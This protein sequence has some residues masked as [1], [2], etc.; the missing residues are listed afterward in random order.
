M[1]S[2]EKSRAWIEVNRENLLYN[3][4]VAR[5]RL[6]VDTKIMAVV[7]AQAYGH[8]LVEVSK[9]FEEKGV[10]F[11]A[12]ACLS[13]AIM[14][15]EHGICGDIL[16]LGYTDI[17]CMDLVK[18]YDIIQ[19]GINCE[20]VREID[21]LGL[22]IRIHLKV[23]T[24]MH[25]IGE[26]IEHF[27]EIRS[28]FDLE[29][30]KLEGVFSHL[31]VSDM[32]Y[33]SYDEFTLGQIRRYDEMI[34]RLFES[35]YQFKTHIQSSSGMLNYETP[36]FHSYVRPGIMLYGV[37][38]TQKDLREEDIMLKPALE[39]KAR[40]G[41]LNHLKEGESIGYGQTYTAKRDMD[42]A[43]ITIGYADG[44]PRALSNVGRIVLNG[45]Y[46]NIVGRVC[47][48]QLMVDIS[49][50]PK[51]DV[52][53]IATLIGS[54]GEACVSVYEVATHSNTITN[55]ILSSLGERLPRIYI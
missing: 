29:H 25:R 4:N 23:D 13:E 55:E 12:T 38:S 36:H 2:L 8:G 52:G 19:T 51:V 35:G 30:I 7:K 22:G 26:S 40:V 42:I 46:A 41:A 5:E 37:M 50:I 32:P 9:F 17:S 53:D 15:R 48:D 45:K 21:R 11:F 24:G 10:D 43:V 14:L 6:H 44:I 1:L 16:V 18:K 34:D 33:G 39:I 54:Q 49:D 31:N 20:Y 27:E 47:M 28:M 3:L